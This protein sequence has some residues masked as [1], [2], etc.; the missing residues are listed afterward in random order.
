LLGKP[1]T[2]VIL[3]G[4][5]TLDPW[6]P[7]KYLTPPSSGLH[8]WTTGDTM[9][10]TG[11]RISASARLQRRRATDRVQLSI[12]AAFRR[13]TK[14]STR[15]SP[16]VAHTRALVVGVM[17]GMA[18]L[19]GCH[20]STTQ[21]SLRIEAE[22]MV[23]LMHIRTRTMVVWMLI[24]VMEQEG[25]RLLNPASTAEWNMPFTRLRGLMC[26]RRPSRRNRGREHALH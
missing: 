18:D 6:P 1:H 17:V 26:N 2:T 11:T 16:T 21:D 8:Q 3:L 23:V 24:T 19:V 9:A 13:G 10:A 14:G 22:T 20:R 5:H 15:D 4:H 25:S 7:P 12:E